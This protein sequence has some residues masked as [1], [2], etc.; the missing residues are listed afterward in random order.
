MNKKTKNIVS[1]VSYYQGRCE[2]LPVTLSQVNKH[3]KE[4]IYIHQSIIS[5]TDCLQHSMKVLFII[6]DYFLIDPRG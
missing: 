1:F 2:S 6:Y 3:K 4:P 5:K